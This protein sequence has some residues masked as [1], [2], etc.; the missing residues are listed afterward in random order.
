M[1]NPAEKLPTSP[2][3]QRADGSLDAVGMTRDIRHQIAEELKKRPGRERYAWLQ[4]EAAKLFPAFKDI[5]KV[6]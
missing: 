2:P 3:W 4:E 5:S 6:H 1:S